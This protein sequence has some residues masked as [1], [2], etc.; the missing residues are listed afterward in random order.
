MRNLAKRTTIYDD[1]SGEIIHDSIRRGTQNG[2]G[3]VIMY[4]DAL[5]DLALNAPPIALKIFLALSSKQEFE[6]GIK[7]TKKAISTEFSISYNNVMRGFN[8]LKENGYLK[9][10]KTDGVSEFLLNPDVTTCGKNKK[11]KLELWNSF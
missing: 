1:E 11:K 8:W 10:R 9:E 2:D 3:W 5:A 6:K 7:A 4:R